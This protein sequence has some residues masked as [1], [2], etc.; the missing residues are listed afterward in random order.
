MIKGNLLSA[1]RH[2]INLFVTVRHLSTRQILYQIKSRLTRK[3][4]FL[5]VESPILCDDIVNVS[6]KQTNFTPRWTGGSVCLENNTFT[7]LNLSKSYR[8]INWCDD[9]LGGL[10]LDHLH[11]F[12]F[13]ELFTNNKNCITKSYQLIIDWNAN[14]GSCSKAFWPPYNASERAFCISRWLLLSKE[15][16]DRDQISQ[17]LLIVFQDIDFV[18]RNLEWNLDGNHLLKNL[19]IIWWGIEIFDKK[20]TTKWEGLLNNNLKKVVEEQILKDGM[21]YEKSYVYH[22]IALIDFLD[23][24]SL[25][26]VKS[27]SNSSSNNILKNLI[28][29]MLLSMEYMT[30][31]DGRG[32]LFN[33]SPSNL[34]SNPVSV[35]AHARVNMS[36]NTIEDLNHLRES[37]YIQLKNSHDFYIITDVGNLGPDNQLGHAHSDMLHFEMSYKNYRVLVEG[38]TSNYYDKKRRP[39]ERS[40][41]AHNSVT[42]NKKSQSTNW[43]NFRVSHRGHCKVVDY[44]WSEGMTM[45]C[46]EHDGFE[47]KFGI[48]HRRS[49]E[50]K[51][52]VFSVDDILIGQ[53]DSSL[54]V[55]SFLHFSNECDLKFSKGIL[56]I[57][58]N[59]QYHLYMKAYNAEIHIEQMKY[60]SQYNCLIS[61]NRI[62]M[63]IFDNKLSFGFVISESFDKVVASK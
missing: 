17:I 59:G 45:L 20:I 6:F 15:H 48:I 40:T 39:Y 7:F 63:N 52:G 14:K 10:W 13:L 23:I 62:R 54:I 50:F 55:E 22:Q 42:I 33:D 56:T 25:V 34:S 51:K 44:R 58:I 29:K 27:S 37:G 2:I 41:E 24:Y 18:S 5:K 35:I 53:A 57:C 3:N 11:Y 9:S 43:S 49:F 31:P 12:R 60:A 38:G 46:A 47:S 4:I 61:G 21:H 1:Y 30:H 36:D 8:A 19:S 16:L 28:K 26:Q 32:C